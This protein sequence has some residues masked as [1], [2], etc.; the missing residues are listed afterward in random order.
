MLVS[1]IAFYFGSNEC[2]SFKKHRQNKKPE[3]QQ[4]KEA[5]TEK[6]E[7]KSQFRQE[8]KSLHRL[9]LLV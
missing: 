7:E 5:E 6:S 2:L 3:I 8:H 1:Y 4:K 9:G